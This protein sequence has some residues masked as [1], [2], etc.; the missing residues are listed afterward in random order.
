MSWPEA[1]IGEVGEIIRGVTFSKSDVMTPS[2][3]NV[4][5]V[6]RAGNIGEV[7][8]TDNDLVFVSSSRVSSRQALRKNDIVVCMSSGSATVVGKNAI[9]TRS[10]RGSFGA[11]LA[12]VRP[13]DEKVDP[14][15]LSHYMRSQGFRAWASGAQGIGIKNIRANELLAHSIPLPPLP[16]QKRIAA[17][18][19]QADA[20]RRLRARAREKVNALGQAIFQEM[21]GD[22][23]ESSSVSLT[24]VLMSCGN[25]MTVDQDDSGTGVPVTRIETIWNG[26]IDA[27]RVKWT[28]IVIDAAR[29][30]FLNSGDI[31]FSHINSPKHIAK[32]AIYTGIPENLLHGINLLRLQPDKS[33]VAP[34]WLLFF[35]KSPPVREFFRLRCKQAVNQASLNQKNLSD[36]RFSLP[37]LSRQEEFARHVSTVVASISEHDRALAMSNTLFSSLQHRAFR[38]EL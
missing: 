36:L 1:E 4:T 22:P 19:D 9:L 31:L 6:L 32:T 18:L 8:D 30:H 11:F 12:A 27:A 25:G 13:N 7:L 3:A 26:N 16:E 24:D 2:D 23:S 34:V 29:K 35:L 14:N 33:K 17:I 15:Y 38:G 37:L 20:L 10:W 21:F 5:P 28:T